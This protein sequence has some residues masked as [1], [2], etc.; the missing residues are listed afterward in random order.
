MAS[1]ALDPGDSQ[2]QYVFDQRVSEQREDYLTSQLVAFNQTHSTVLSIERHDLLPL[3]IYVLDRAGAV[4]G[5]VVG[6]THAIPLWFE[7]SV[8]WIEERLRH[9]GLGRE[10]LRQA[11][12]EAYQRGCRYARLATSNFQAPAFYE[13]MGY[14]L[15]G[16]LEN[17]PPGETVFYFWKR[18][19]P[20]VAPPGR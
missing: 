13:K 11:E 3:H 14:M 15:Y 9:Q 10:L 18:L 2:D 8:I 1:N 6:R 5:G 20:L 4:L 7:I 16:T 17:C 19:A 12:Q